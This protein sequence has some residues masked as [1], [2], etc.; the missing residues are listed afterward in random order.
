MSERRAGL[1]KDDARADPSTHA[2]KAGRAG[3]VREERTQSPC[4]GSGDG[5]Y[6]GENA[7]NTGSP[8][9]WSVVTT[10]LEPVTVRQGAMGWRRGPYYRGSR[11]MPAEGRG[12]GSRLVLEV[13]KHGRLG[14][15][16]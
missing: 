10:N 12:L 1:E 7:R 6:T 3:E 15:P 14:Q 13:A 4:R 11:V 16:Y 8:M 9:A 2:G 5:M